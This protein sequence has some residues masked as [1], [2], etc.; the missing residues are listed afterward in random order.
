MLKADDMVKLRM[1]CPRSSTGAVIEE[2]YNARALDI[3]EHSK[4]EFLDIGMPMK[5]SEAMSDA[6]VKLRSVMFQLG[7]GKDKDERFRELEFPKTKL[8]EIESL[9][10]D[11]SRLTAEARDID[12]RLKLLSETAANLEGVDRLGISPGLLQKTGL[13]VFFLGYVDDAKSLELDLSDKVKTGFEVISAVHDNRQLACLFIDRNSE[14]DA[15]NI[16]RE[17]NFTELKISDEFCKKDA[18][19]SIRK[20]TSALGKRKKEL[21]RDMEKLRRE[22]EKDIRSTEKALSVSLKKAEAPL[23]FAETR[24][25]SVISGWVPK[26]ARQSLEKGLEKTTAKKI[27]IEELET[28]KEDSVPVKLDNPLPARP[29]EFLLRLFSIPSYRELDPTIFVFITFPLF[30]GFMLGDIGYGLVIA[31]LL[32]YLMKRYPDSKDLFKIMMFSAVSSIIFGFVFGE[33]FGFE[34]AQL[35]YVQPLIHNFHYPFIERGAETATELIEI[36][37]VFGVLHVNFGLILGFINVL[38]QHG[39]KHAIFEKF[40]WFLVEAGAVIALLSGFGVIGIGNGIWPGIMVGLAIVLI[41]AVMLFLGEGIQGILE[42]PSIFVHIGSYMRLMAIGLA[43]VSLA[44]VIND[45]SAPLLHSGIAGLIGGILL[46]TIGHI[47]NIAL[48]V[49]GPFLHSLR[50]HYVEHFTK[51]YKGG[52]REFSPFGAG[53]D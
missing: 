2:L 21:E 53:E 20:E 11:V 40:S 36:S 13:L 30:F 33:F 24:N 49:I 51:F 34:I 22:K 6:L 32:V 52:G 3:I 12:A 1:F 26:K 37:G 10:S 27:Y 35:S 18:L 50:L 44:I 45:Q 46:F 17:H 19:K 28:G 25:V 23:M 31:I 47:F 15:M 8:K 29:Y 4:D 48:G 7:I 5:D 9:H 38:R 16:L 42:L 39:L 43:S 14:N 41:A